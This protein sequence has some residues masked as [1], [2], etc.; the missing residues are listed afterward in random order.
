MTMTDFLASNTIQIQI[1]SRSRDCNKGEHDTI[2]KVHTQFE[3]TLIDQ[4][5]STYLQ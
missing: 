3:L 4:I 5:V 1:N 2:D